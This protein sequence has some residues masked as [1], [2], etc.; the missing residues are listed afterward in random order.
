M[1]KIMTQIVVRSFETLKLET[2]LKILTPPEVTGICNPSKLHLPQSQV[3]I[4]AGKTFHYK[5]LCKL[6]RNNELTFFVKFNLTLSVKI[7]L[8]YNTYPLF[9]NIKS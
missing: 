5:V 7:V 3:S 2:S 9:Y 4:R 6:H 1:V 8:R